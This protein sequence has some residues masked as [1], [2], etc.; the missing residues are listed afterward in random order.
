MNKN[1]VKYP[2]TKNYYITEDGEV[3]KI[4]TGN[5]ESDRNRYVF[6]EDK[7]RYK[8][9]IKKAKKLYNEFTGT[10]DN[11]FMLRNELKIMNLSNKEIARFI[12][13]T[14]KFRSTQLWKIEQSIKDNRLVLIVKTNLTFG[15]FYDKITEM[16]GE[17]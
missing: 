8:C 15:V 12:Q 14:K 9:T 6:T 17:Y 3:V 5:F 10:Y 4:I 13:K 1:L 16:I 2:N 11:E 7:K